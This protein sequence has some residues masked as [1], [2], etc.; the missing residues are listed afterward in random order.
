M[1]YTEFYDYIDSMADDIMDNREYWDEDTLGDV[2]HEHCDDSQYVIYNGMAW[3]LV[4]YFRMN[5]WDTYSIAEDEV[6]SMGFEWD[7]ETDRLMCWLSYQLI[8]NA[9]NEELQER[10]EALEVAA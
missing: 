9:L 2:I 1:T 6:S 5:H 3:D 10:L 8:S 7:G 4:S